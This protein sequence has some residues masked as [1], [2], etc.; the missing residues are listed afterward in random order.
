MHATLLCSVFLGI[1]L[2]MKP[3]TYLMVSRATDRTNSGSPRTNSKLLIWLGSTGKLWEA[4]L[5][6]LCRSLAKSSG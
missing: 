6:K 5:L 1:H 2:K 4:L 3:S